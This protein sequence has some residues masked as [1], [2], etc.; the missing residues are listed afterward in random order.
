MF[1]PV[2]SYAEGNF[3]T[4][5]L[6]IWVLRIDAQRTQL[7]HKRRI[8]ERYPMPQSGSPHFVHK[9]YR[10]P[11]NYKEERNQYF[12][13]TW[14]WRNFDFLLGTPKG[15]LPP[16]RELPTYP[17][18]RINTTA[19]WQTTRQQ[20]QHQNVQPTPREVFFS[21]PLLPREREEDSRKKKEERR[22]KK[23]ERREKTK[24]RRRKRE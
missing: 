14:R 24:D 3:T 15:H 21:L 4:K 10:K 19:G 1:C 13:G 6:I 5:L 22:K 16:Y 9:Q 18:C 12:A 20:Q 17:H 7:L 2:P 8:G 11:K 23:E